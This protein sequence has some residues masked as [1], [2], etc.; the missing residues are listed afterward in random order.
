MQHGG[1]PACW[2][3]YAGGALAD[4]S[5]TAP[6][7]FGKFVAVK[8]T[9]PSVPALNPVILELGSPATGEGIG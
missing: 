5:P 7:V 2:V 8:N 4:T 6:S 1:N 9:I 3:T